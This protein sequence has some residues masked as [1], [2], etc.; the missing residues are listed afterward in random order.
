MIVLRGYEERR[1]IITST[2]RTRW[3]DWILLIG[4]IWLFV[5]P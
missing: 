4:G 2:N 5:A 3:Q 1:L